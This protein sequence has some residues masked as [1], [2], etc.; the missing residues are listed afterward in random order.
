MKIKVKKRDEV[1]WEAN[2]EIEHRDG[3]DW[4]WRHIN[5]PEML[6]AVVRHGGG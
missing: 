2:M 5:G 6:V 4:R 1:K 3:G